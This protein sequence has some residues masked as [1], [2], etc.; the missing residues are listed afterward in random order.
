MRGDGR[1][2]INGEEGRFY[3]KIE[4]RDKM[5]RLSKKF[6]YGRWMRRVR[7]DTLAR[8]PSLGFTFKHKK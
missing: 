2:R 5:T 1:P 6:A 7:P 3:G 4:A 8:G